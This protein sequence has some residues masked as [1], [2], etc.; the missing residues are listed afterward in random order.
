MGGFS[1]GGS[2]TAPHA[3]DPGY[4]SRH[5]HKRRDWWHGPVTLLLG[6]K[7]MEWL[8]ESSLD[9]LTSEMNLH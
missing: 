9:N 7:D 8:E 5:L 1:S 4:D 6:D 3:E 2:V